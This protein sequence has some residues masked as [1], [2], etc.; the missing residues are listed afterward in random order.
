MGLAL[1][2]APLVALLIIIVALS[3]AFAQPQQPLQLQL[4]P[5]SLE[6]TPGTE[7]S[8]GLKQ[9][10]A[11][12][13]HT[14]WIN[15]GDSGYA[16]M[17]DWE[18]PSG[19]DF[20][21]AAWPAPSRLQFAGSEMFGY[22]ASSTPV[23][24][25]ISAAALQ[26]GDTLDIIAHID[27]LVCSDRC[28]PVIKDLRVTLT[29]AAAPTNSD[30]LHGASSHLPRM[31]AA[32]GRLFVSHGELI[33]E[34]PSLE[35]KD[36]LA[37]TTGSLTGAD[38]FFEEGEV[39]TSGF[40]AR[41][42]LVR[43]LLTIDLGPARDELSIGSVNAVLKFPSGN[44][45]R[46]ILRF[47]DAAPLAPHAPATGLLT[48]ALFAFL[49]GLI[50]NLMP[51]VFPVLS[52]KLMAIARA[53]D[54][55][56]AAR[57]EALFFGAGVLASFM[58]LALAI[59]LAKHMGAVIGWGFQLQSP[60]I[61]G[62][63]SAVMLLIALNMSGLFETGAAI[64]TLAGNAGTRLT[65]RNRPAFSA[66]F[67][68]VLAVMV[69][70][71]C[72]APFMATAIGAALVSQPAETAFI[73][74]A[75]G[76]GFAA[77]FVILVYAAT[78]SPAFITWLPRPGP[79]MA[80]LRHVLAVPMYAAA[81]WLLWVFFRQTN[82][83]M[84]ALFGVALALV[85]FIL[86]SP[87]QR[88][89][90]ASV[91]IIF[92]IIAAF[93]GGLVSTPAPLTQSSMQPSRIAFS[94]EALNLLT[95]QGR[96]VFVDMTADWCVTCKVNEMRVLRNASIMHALAKQNVVMMVGDWTRHDP[97]ITAYINSFDRSGVPLYV[98]Y[99]GQGGAPQI[100]PQLL[101]AEMLQSAIAPSESL[102]SASKN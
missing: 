52:I 72:T 11:P 83:L 74:A 96:P 37:S 67:T 87:R 81:L 78:F 39:A 41:F 43:N 29:V 48:M 16:P 34:I 82:L 53:G 62:A 24:R 80:K 58:V 44:S 97:A 33:A 26:P 71:P 59:E 90:F 61:T 14:Y 51:C 30:N 46:A 13:W 19:V 5:Q 99:D 27:D 55:G 23:F 8:I 93:S 38:L 47:D 85:I 95:K 60:V 65:M 6:I 36:D 3:P 9:T 32:E 101:N 100:L 42:S 75:L 76:L 31:L 66:F 63:L 22:S 77:P 49:G 86:L 12:G 28:V 56:A 35:L 98:Y 4:V 1:S 79:W 88:I 25:F 2:R 69:A 7:F 18:L 92:S 15:P 70:A 21:S 94:Q 20:V 68:G 89:P 17:V 102:T 54:D 64:Q 10:P 50:L 84:A 40:Q 45:Y 57:R 91:L 73:F